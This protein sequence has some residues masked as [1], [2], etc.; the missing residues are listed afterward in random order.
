M[1]HVVKVTVVCFL[2]IHIQSLQWSANITSL[3]VVHMGPDA[4]MITYVMTKYRHQKSRLRKNLISHTAY[5][6][7][8]VLRHLVQLIYILEQV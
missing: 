2:M 7:L 8:T 3:A 1:V 4:V 6:C 5:R